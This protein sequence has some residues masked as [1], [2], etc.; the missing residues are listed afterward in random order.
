M[1]A[2]QPGSRGYNYERTWFHSDVSLICVGFNPEKVCPYQF[3]NGDYKPY[4]WPYKSGQIIATSHEF[5][6]QNVGEISYFREIDRLVKCYSKG[7]P[8]YPCFAYPRHPQTP[9]WKEFRTIN[10]WLGVWGMLQGFVGKF[11]ELYFGQIHGYWGFYRRKWSYNNPTTC[12][13]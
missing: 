11:I 1:S 4:K 10:C 12:D 3:L 5:S 6:P 13:W 9:K 7:I 8:T 2:K